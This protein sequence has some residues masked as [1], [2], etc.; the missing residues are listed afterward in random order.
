MTNNGYFYFFVNFVKKINKKFC[1]NLNFYFVKKNIDLNFLMIKFKIYASKYTV[2]NFKF[3]I[4]FNLFK[5]YF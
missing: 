5:K 2:Y 1:I 3:F 4:S